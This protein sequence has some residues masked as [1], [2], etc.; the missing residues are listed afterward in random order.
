MDKKVNIRITGKVQGVYFRKHTQE[1]AEALDIHGSVLNKKDGSVEIQ[2]VGSEEDIDDFIAFCHVG[3]PAAEVESVRVDPILNV[4]KT[5]F[6]TI[7]P[8]EK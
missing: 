3:S 6:F 4:E 8:S 5:S 7:L 1:K 2:A